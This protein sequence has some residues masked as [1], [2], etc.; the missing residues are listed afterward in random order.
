MAWDDEEDN[1]DDVASAFVYG[2][3]PD[4]DP[5]APTIGGGGSQQLTT[6]PT[7]P[8]LPQPKSSPDDDGLKPPSYTP[9]PLPSMP[10]SHEDEYR[11]LE[12]T[13]TA[14]APT[15]SDPGLKPSIGR[16]VGAGIATAL[17]GFGRIPNA[18]QVGSDALYS[19]YNQAR[20]AFDTQ[21]AQAKEQMSAL[22]DQSQME[23]QGWERG[24]QAHNA[25]LA[26]YNAQERG[27]QGQQLA[28]DRR[29]QEQQRLQAIAPGSES[30]DDPKNPLGGWHATTVGG[31][32]IRMQGPPDTWRKTPEGIQA[33]READVTRLRLT[34]DDA[35][36]YRAN[37]KLAEPR[38]KNE[39]EGKAEF[40][41]YLGTLGHPPT[42]EDI[43]NYKHGTG[44]GGRS[45]GGSNMSRTLM[46][47]IESQKDVAL[48]K[49]R[50]QYGDGKSPDYTFDDYMNDWQAA[51]DGFEDR[52]STATGEDVPHVDVRSHVDKKGNWIAG[53]GQQASASQPGPA[54]GDK[55]ASAGK[56][57]YRGKSYTK[58]QS[59][60][61]G[62][63]TY[64]VQGINPKTGKLIVSRPGA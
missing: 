15:P 34:G 60:Q 64:V 52:I 54:P 61:V 21:Q 29:A 3:K 30:P 7:T 53:R 63:Q 20:T 45:G 26:D 23:S 36:Y 16:R 25:G 14:K 24:L 31:K 2:A 49:A 1:Q 18:A 11:T 10:S 9:T 62:D 50:Q 13:L 56:F 38:Q 27:Y 28:A 12:R 6:R 41:A 46:D 37:G 42:S 48:S 58:G 5:T 40:D 39:P 59:V 35:K 32:P 47:R 33:Q 4:A 19:K 22:R 44:R 51:Q 17:M 57:S 43:L 8:A 55:N